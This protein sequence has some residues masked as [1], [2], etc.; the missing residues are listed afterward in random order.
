MGL[1]KMRK[2]IKAIMLIVKLSVSMGRSF[3][4][5]TACVVLF[6]NLVNGKTQATAKLL[7]LS[8]LLTQLMKVKQWKMNVL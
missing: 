5:V 6:N 1:A 3:F 4:S 8:G 2:I 7:I